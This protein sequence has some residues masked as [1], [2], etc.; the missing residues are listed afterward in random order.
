MQCKRTFQFSQVVQQ[1]N[2][3]PEEVALAESIKCLLD[4]IRMWTLSNALS[5]LTFFVIIVHYIIIQQIVRNAVKI[6]S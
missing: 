3:L 5:L 4:K 6:A 2:N 1:W